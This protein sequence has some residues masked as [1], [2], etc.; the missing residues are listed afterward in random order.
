MRFVSASIPSMH[1]SH[2]LPKPTIPG[3]FN[4]PL[5]M[6][7]S[8]PPPSICAVTFTLGFFR[9][10][11]NAPTPFGPYILCALNAIRSMPSLFTST[12]IL[13]TACV[14]SVKT[15]TPCF[16]AIALISLI[17]MNGTDLVIGIHDRNQNRCRLNSRFQFFQINQTI[18]LSPADRLLRRQFFQY[19]YR[20][21]VPL[22]VL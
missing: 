2:A 17:G 19:A 8:W 18:A 10:T 21:P 22:Y 6:P 14:A 12:G 11:Y 9:R 3:T 1:N 13:P 4:V 5:R 7:L 16:L 15:S 20:Y